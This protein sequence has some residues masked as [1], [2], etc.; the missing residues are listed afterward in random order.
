MQTAAL[1][2]HVE[3]KYGG[4]TSYQKLEKRRNQMKQHLYITQRRIVR[5]AI[6]AAILVILVCSSGALAQSVA[7]SGEQKNMTLVGHVGLQGRGAYQ[8]NVITSPDGRVIAF[9]GLHNAP[10]LGGAPGPLPNPLNGGALEEN[11][12]LI[13]EARQS[14]VSG[15]RVGLGG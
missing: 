6:C 9:A 15:K 8:P 5:T 12:T 11:R 4:F 14:G 10:N 3:Q 1:W 13:I 2:H 7:Q